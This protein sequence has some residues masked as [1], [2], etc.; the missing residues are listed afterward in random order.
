M[1]TNAKSI[2]EAVA[3][4]ATGAEFRAG[5][6]DVQERIRS[7]NLSLPLIDIGAISGL[8]EIEFHESG[9]TVGALTDL[10]TLSG[11]A[12]LQQDYPALTLPTQT[13]A[14]PQI[15]NFATLGGA[16][17]QRS[18]CWYFRHPELGCPKKGNSD[19]C[20]AREGNHERGVCFDLGPCVAPHPSSVGCALLTYDAQIEVTGRGRIS[21]AELFGDGSDATRDHTLEKGQMI[22]HIQLPKPM[23]NEKAAYYRMMSRKWAEWPAVEVVARL[24]LEGE[25][26]T[27]AKVAI[28]A[29][30]NIP[31]R[32]TEVEELLVGAPAN[33]KTFQSAAQI[34]VA[35]ANP[36][37][38]T[39]HKLKMVVA[40]VFH[41]L[42]QRS[43]QRDRANRPTESQRV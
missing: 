12:R 1:H 31:L 39:G 4:H 19:T 40:S 20:T 43:Q 30:A 11:H 37:P 23:E 10:T 17:C 18:R 28:G 6:T 15:R 5:G 2:D 13:L 25:T 14:T 42:Q 32:L 38:Q 36:L 34:S 21:V 7:G 41:T 22:T 26:I 3:A 24:K 35:R 8:S 16:L 9:A 33:D 27:D 29:V